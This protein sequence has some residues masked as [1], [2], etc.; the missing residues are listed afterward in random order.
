MTSEE[1][2]GY[3]AITVAVL[4][5]CAGLSTHPARLLSFL[6]HLRRMLNENR[7]SKLLVPELSVT[8]I[9]PSGSAMSDQSARLS[10]D[11]RLLGLAGLGIASQAV[12]ASVKWSTA[13]LRWNRDPARRRRRNASAEA[14]P[15]QVKYYVL[16]ATIGAASLSNGTNKVITD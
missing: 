3:L 16:S 2:V 4:A 10:R 8:A 1:L 13:V 14:P 6:L 7:F 9:A 12:S 15:R 5:M 11:R